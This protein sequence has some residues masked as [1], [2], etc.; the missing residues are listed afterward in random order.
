[1]RGV[2]QHPTQERPGHQRPAPPARSDASMALLADLMGNTLEGG[3]AEA[4]ARRRA[5]G[6]PA[7][8]LRSTPLLVLGLALVGLLLA[9]AAAQVRTRAAAQ[10]TAR[11]AL[12]T[13]VTERTAANDRLAAELEALQ[14]DVASTRAEQLELAGAGTG[15][16]RRLAALEGVTGAAAVAG[17]GIVLTVDDA[18]DV[19]AGGGPDP[20]EAAEQDQGR[21]RD[22]DLQRIVNGLWAA[23][24]EAVA[25]NG[26]RLTSLTAIRSAGQAVLVGYRPLVPPYVI[27]AVGDPAGME[28]RFLAGEAG[29]YLD[30]VLEDSFGIRYTLEQ[31]QE[32]TLPGASGIA[33]RHAAVPEA[34]EEAR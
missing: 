2:M 10:E 28:T 11:A 19:T 26:Q 25:V 4:T 8:M 31:A 21:V 16:A 17:P 34:G 33:L 23:G 6:R 20:R 3:Y 12:V 13:E 7:G 5:A 32:L 24:A 18:E 14:A 1:M 15:L 27:Q 30:V 22:R 29:L 9:T